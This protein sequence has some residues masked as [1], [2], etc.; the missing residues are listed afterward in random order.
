[1]P[2]RP[3]TPALP[4][5]HCPSRLGRRLRREEEEEEEEEE[6]EEEEEERE[7]ER[8]EGRMTG[9]VLSSE[10]LFSFS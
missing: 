9:V 10:Y 8:G 1:M 2:T 3:L 7:R 5:P 6:G 4:H